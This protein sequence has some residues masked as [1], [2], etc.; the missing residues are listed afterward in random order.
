MT[1]GA[2]LGPYEITVPLGSGGMGEVYKATDTRLGRTV[3]I[4]VLPADVAADEGRKI[5]FER[6]AQ[7]VAALNH[8]HICV[9]H[10]IG[11]HPS[12]GSGQIDFLVLEYLQGETLAPRLEEGPI[13]LDQ[14]LRY[15]MQVADALDKAHRGG[16]VHRDLKPGNVMLTK[17]GVKLLDFGLAKLRDASPAGVVS[18]SVAA[19][20][21]AGLTGEGTILGTL[22]Y[23]APEQLE[24][25]D[26][27]ARADI[28]AFGTLLYEMLT[29]KKAFEGTS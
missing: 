14:A 11:R 27:E 18:Q 28:F 21:N 19:T 5:R 23:I 13:P 9:L 7:A 3:A 4:K 25:R 22:Q 8:P 15:A 1:P 17:S 20:M 2:R 16:V 26:A 10:D 12:T 24:G 6:E 29:G